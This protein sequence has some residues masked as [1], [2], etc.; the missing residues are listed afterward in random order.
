MYGNYGASRRPE[1]VPQ[2][3]KLDDY[4]FDENEIKE[5]VQHELDAALGQDGG[6]LSQERLEAQRQYN[7]EAVGPLAP[8][9]GRSS[10]VMRTVLEAVEWVL[11]AL[12]RIFTASDKIVVVEPPFPGLEGK[13]QQ[14][15]D[16]V[17]HI[18]YRDNPGFMILRDWFADALLEK[19]GWVKYYWDTQKVTETRSFTGLTQEQYDAVK[20]QDA[21]VEIVKERVYS[22]EADEFFRD[23]PAPPPPPPVATFQAPGMPAPLLPPPPV[24]LY[25]CTLRITR[26]NGRVVIANVAPEEVLFS[27]RSKRGHMPFLAHRRRWSYSDLVQ[28]GYDEDCLDLVPH[29]GDSMEQNQER[30]ERYKEDDF[31]PYERTGA[32]REIWTEESYVPLS[33][34][35]RTTELYKVTSA[36]KGLII[37]TKDGKPDI[38]CV[39]E[40]PF[41]P[42]CPIPQSHK[43]VGMSLAELVSDIQTIKSVLMRQMLDNA[44]LSNWPRVEVPDDVANENTYDDLL[45]MRPGG[46]IRTRRGGGLN[47]VTIPFTADKSFPLVEYMDRTAEAR[48]GVS[49]NQSI[50]PDALNTMTNNTATGM[51]LMQNAAAQRVELFA[52]IFA[53]GVEQLM[54]GIMGLV[55]RHQQQERIIRVTGGWLQVDPREWRDEM[56]VTVSV[57]LGTGNR[58]Q[59]LAHLMQVVQLQGNIVKEQGGVNGPLVY[60][61][62]VYAALHE[63]TTNAGF[64]QAFFA[65][66]SQ[67]PPPPPPGMPP[68]GPQ[69]PPDPAIQKAQAA[70]QAA[71][72]KAQAD[73]QAQQ[74][75]AQT[76]M[77]LGQQKAQMEAQLAQQRLQHEMMLE[78]KR[79]QHEMQLES[80]KSANDIAIAKAQAEALAAVQMREIELKYAAGAYSPRPPPPSNG[81]A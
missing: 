26:T 14:A 74:Q 43:L 13:A 15:T 23:R 30:V 32:A 33:R 36:G 27:Q 52:R 41:V 38:E 69:K 54:R 31:P 68:G 35:D 7:G 3:L 65:D 8:I 20:G 49:P 48:T 63:L 57:G 67:P 51:A 62:N 75:K 11:P 25:D 21:D 16:Y 73:A 61:T 2:G 80:Q 18:F 53:F 1:P 78:E 42:L 5:I 39:D 47:A 19:L 56:P 29:D 81:A 60:A 17:N 64:K 24:T 4:D 6:T 34:D 12:L 22:Q 55:R 37:L 9:E 79:L 72:M 59:I 44:F 10:I 45:T 40:V 71:Q 77:A 70:I 58:D 46:V 50:G 28:Q 76:E 66:P